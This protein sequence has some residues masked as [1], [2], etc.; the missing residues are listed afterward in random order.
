MYIQNIYNVLFFLPA[1]E[2]FS[3]PFAMAFLLPTIFPLIQPLQRF[4]S[5]C[6]FNESFLVNFF[7]HF[8]QE[9][10]REHALSLL[11]C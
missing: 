10:I 8:L 3:L 2:L 9:K 7:L 1:N 11:A 6:F 4:K 5:R